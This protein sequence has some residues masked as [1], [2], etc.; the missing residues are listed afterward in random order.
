MDSTSLHSQIEKHLEEEVNRKFRLRLKELESSLIDKYPSDKDA[1]KTVIAKYS[2]PIKSTLRLDTEKKTRKKRD[3]PEETRCEARTGN[4][5]QCRRPKS[6]GNIYC[7]SHQHT[8]PHG[9]INETQTVSLP[10]V[11]KRGRKKKNKCD[12]RTE[13]LDQNLY[14]QAVLLKLDDA[15]YLV[16]ENHVIY[17]YGDNVI[18]GYIN[19]ECEVCWV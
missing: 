1:V 3:L 7:L 13:D 18:V 17:K 10:A 2:Y 16:D 12:F 11:N 4:N 19:K 14:I 15:I 8:L 6:D 9:N 5:T